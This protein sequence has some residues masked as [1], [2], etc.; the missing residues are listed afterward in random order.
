MMK[1]RIKLRRESR[2]NYFKY[3]TKL[4]FLYLLFF[5]YIFLFLTFIFKRPPKCEQQIIVQPPE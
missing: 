4:I 1:T 2:D 3:I 5:I